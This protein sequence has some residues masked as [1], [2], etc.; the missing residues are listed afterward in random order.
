MKSKQGSS[1]RKIVLHF[2]LSSQGEG[3]CS[4][5][6]REPADD[7]VR[8]LSP[9]ELAS[10]REPHRTH[11]H[12][13]CLQIKRRLRTR[14]CAKTYRDHL[15]LRSQHIVCRVNMEES[16]TTQKQRHACSSVREYPRVSAYK[17]RNRAH[18]YGWI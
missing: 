12:Q 4:G 14:L 15:A 9:R 10:S 7:W 2:F 6:V 1:G 11:I 8:M 16:Q 5:Y 13:S 17:V 18:C 3:T